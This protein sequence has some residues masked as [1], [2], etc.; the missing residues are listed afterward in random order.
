M[1]YIVCMYVVKT[2]IYIE[3]TAVAITMF[4]I[5]VCYQLQFRDKNYKRFAIVVSILTSIRM[6]TNKILYN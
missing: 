5:N 1:Q 2:G 6:I 4:V 3:C